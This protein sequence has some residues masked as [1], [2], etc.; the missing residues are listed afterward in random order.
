MK[1]TL[2]SIAIALIFVGSILGGMLWVLSLGHPPD[3]PYEP[4][5]L[6]RICADGSYVW[7]NPDTGALYAPWGARF[8]RDIPLDQ[9]CAR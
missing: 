9:T 4:R 3:R 7:R 6:V 8:A 1:E 2:I 5:E